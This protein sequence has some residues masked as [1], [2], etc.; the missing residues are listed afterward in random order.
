MQAFYQHKN[1]ALAVT[2]ATCGVPFPVDDGGRPVPFI[3]FYDGA[4]LKKILGPDGAPLY[5]GWNVQDAARDAWQRGYRG[6][7]VYQSQ[8]CEMLERILKAYDKHSDLIARS[9]A[10]GLPIQ[11]TL[12]I[13]PETAARLCCQFTKNRN[14]FQEGWRTVVPYVEIS[15]TSRRTTEGGHT[16]I[17]GKRTL[18]RLSNV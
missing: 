14:T 12:D 4:T 15:S 6:T 18:A 3:H 8:R 1:L 11:T 16:A 5:A 10:S 9:E 7:V 17:V 2:L 13:D